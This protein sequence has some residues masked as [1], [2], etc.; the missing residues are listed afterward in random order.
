[1]MILQLEVQWRHQRRILV[2]FHP[3]MK[4]EVSLIILL[5]QVCLAW[6]FNLLVRP[7]SQLGISLLSMCSVQCRKTGKSK[8]SLILEHRGYIALH[9]SR[10]IVADL[11]VY[12]S[13]L[14]NFLDHKLVVLVVLASNG[15]E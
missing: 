4:H 7:D 12:T 10:D 8:A 3:P 15:A 14:L 1:M 5:L 9:L 11:V 2:G 6:R 13:F